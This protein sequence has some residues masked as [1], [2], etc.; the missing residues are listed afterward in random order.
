MFHQKATFQG[1][2]YRFT[3]ISFSSILTL[4]SF[5]IGNMNVRGGRFVSEIIGVLR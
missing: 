3:V 5:I 1:G 2:C 4:E